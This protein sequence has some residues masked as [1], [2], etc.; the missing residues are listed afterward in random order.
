MGNKAKLKVL[1]YR[2]AKKKKRC[3]GC[4]SNTI[5]VGMVVLSQNRAVLLREAVAA[6]WRFALCGRLVFGAY[7]LGTP[8][9]CIPS[10]PSNLIHIFSI[11]T[12]IRFIVAFALGFAYGALY[13]LIRIHYLFI[14][15]NIHLG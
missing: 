14:L 11:N 4:R 1:Q 8:K 3:S 13:V 15:Y 9:P 2:E 10:K 5:D 6:L 7:G 12:L